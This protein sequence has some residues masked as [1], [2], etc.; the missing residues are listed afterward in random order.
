MKA[1][2]K[3]LIPSFF[4]ISFGKLFREFFSGHERTVK[5][6]INILASLFLRGISV[7][8][9]LILVPLTINYVNPT[10]YGIWL[11]LTSI[12]SWFAFFDMGLGNGLRNKLTEAI[13]KGDDNLSRSYL[14]TAYAIFFGVFGI[15]W[16]IFV[17]VNRYLNWSGLLNA[18]PELN[19][20]LTWLAFIIISYFSL[21]FILK[22]VNTVL[23]ADQKPA[24][25]AFIDMLGQLF[26]LVSIFILTHLTKGSLINLGLGIGL[27][28]VLVLT[29]ATIWYFKRRYKNIIPGIKW[30]N[31]GCARDMMGLGIKFFFLQV[32][33]FVVFGANNIIIA[34][35]FSPDEVT[36]YNVAYK[37]FSM[38]VLVFIIIITPYWSAFT[39]AY[40]RKDTTWMK[41][42]VKKLEKVWMIVASGGIFLLFFSKYFFPLWV[43]NKVLVPFSVSLSLLLFVLVYT[44]LNLYLFLLNGI[45]KVK[46]QLLFYI[47]LCI[48]NIPLLI[49]LGLKLGIEGL[50]AGNILISIPHLI[51]GPVQLKRLIENRASGLWN[52]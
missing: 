45:G 10:R 51:Y 38:V 12:I 7:M 9:T 35:I 23:T 6:K 46:M 47:P 16:L 48:V 36:V 11:T 26:S 21:Q 44:R 32:A 8:T 30:I 37:Y 13:A 24:R 50:I 17:I 41:D 42:S 29:G 31:A 3:N 33:S 14:S 39:D 25:A 34:H 52:Q 2:V 1:F 18:P 19:S 40:V 49:F 15:I 43:G 22:T 27:P 20:E 4:S 28:S 5:A